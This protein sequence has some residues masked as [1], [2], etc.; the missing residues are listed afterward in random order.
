MD[1]SLIET[2]SVCFHRKSNQLNVAKALL[3]QI[4]LLQPQARFGK[5]CLS[6]ILK[7]YF[8]PWQSLA[9]FRARV[10]FFSGLFSALC[11]VLSVL[12]RVLSLCWVFSRLCWALT[13]SVVGLFEC[14]S[15]GAL[16]GSVILFGSFGNLLGSVLS[17]YRQVDQVLSFFS[18][19]YTVLTFRWP[20]LSNFQVLS[21]HLGLHFP[22]FSAA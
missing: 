19:Q 15:F 2:L 18:S 21:F 14:F 17:L 16:L 10:L 8:V 11:W 4:T 1:L 5:I 12:C 3:G 22:R 7:L 13:F 6:K 9:L 20:V